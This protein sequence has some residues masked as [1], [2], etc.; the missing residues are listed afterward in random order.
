MLSVFGL[1]GVS[2]FG[3]VTHMTIT[4]LSASMIALSSCLIEDDGN[5]LGFHFCH[6]ISRIP[7]INVCVCTISLN[8]IQSERLLLAREL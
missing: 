7:H 1:A 2:E 3:G 8:T 4:K 5:Y 6:R